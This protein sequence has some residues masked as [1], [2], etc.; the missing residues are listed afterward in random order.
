[1]PFTLSPV[2]GTYIDWS[3]V[4]AG[5]R[6]HL[7][8]TVE[9]G[10]WYY[11]K[12]EQYSAGSVKNPRLVLD[13]NEAPSRRLAELISKCRST[14]ALSTDAFTDEQIVELFRFRLAGGSRESW[15]SSSLELGRPLWT[16]VLKGGSGQGTLL[17]GGR[18]IGIE[19]VTSRPRRPSKK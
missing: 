10:D 12:L 8:V 18:V 17:P 4:R 13:W 16:T 5:G 19:S 14:G 11:F 15:S 7:K 9:E 3:S 2:F 6:E 1:M